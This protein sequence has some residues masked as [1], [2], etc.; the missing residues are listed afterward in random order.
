[1]KKP[2]LAMIRV[3]GPTQCGKSKVMFRLKSLLE[4][5]GANVVIDNELKMA[6][7][8]GE[9]ESEA[10]WETAMIKDTIW[11]LSEGGDVN[12]NS[13]RSSDHD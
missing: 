12:V 10:M 11:F 8:L 3:T 1:M 9:G 6:S 5:L 7:N 4:G 2:N 13:P